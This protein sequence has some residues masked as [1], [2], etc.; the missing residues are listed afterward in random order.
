MNRWN[1]AWRNVTR[2]R[3]RSLITGGIVAFGFVSLALAGGFMAQSFEGLRHSAIRSGLG[4]IQF[5]DP[6]AFEKSEDRPLAFGIRHAGA[7]LDVLAKDEAVDVV[8]PRLEFFGLISNGSLSVPIAGLGIDPDAETRGSDIPKS[9]QEGHW[10]AATAREVVIGRGLAKL[11]GARVGDSL[12]V[13]AT[14]PDG[15]LN[16]LDVTVGGIADILVKELNE[17]YLAMPLA[18]AQE[19]LTAPDTV[20]RISV[21][22]H[23]PADETAVAARLNAKLRAAGITLGSK[24]WRELAVFYQQVRVLYIGIFGFMG[25]VLLVIVFL[26]TINTTLMSVTER[27]REI[28][29][30]RALGARARRVATGFILEGTLLGVASAAAGALLSLAITLLINLAEIRMPPPPGIAQ[31]IVIHVQ[32]IP[33][34]YLFAATA[35]IATLAVASFFPARRA[36]RAPIVDSL[37]HV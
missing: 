29:T 10:L 6:R 11:L 19:L 30:L 7:A 37:A 21:I 26:S 31:G 3:R 25:T 27:T 18:L 24:L 14:T 2:N 1:I 33:M 4:H 36:A 8:L 9:V 28:G 35:M 13:L 16:A 23:E 15:T 20:S 12:T 34:V 22:L 17:R 32:V 5:A